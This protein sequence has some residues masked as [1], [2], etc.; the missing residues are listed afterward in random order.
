[1]N[2]AA[3]EI[4]ILYVSVIWQIRYQKVLYFFAYANWMLFHVAAWNENIINESLFIS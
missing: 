2:I 3:F 1:M 4:L